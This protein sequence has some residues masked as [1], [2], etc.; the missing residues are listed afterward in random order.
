M[1]QPL[2]ALRDVNLQLGGTHVLQ[3]IDLQLHKARITT[4]IG[5]NGAGKTSLAKVVLGLHTP[6]S[7]TLTRK[8]GLKIGYMPQRL[9]IDDSLPLT[10]DRFLWLADPAHKNERRA[11]LERVDVAELQFKPVQQLSGGE[12][13]RVLLARALLRKADLLV[14]DEPAQGVDV[15]GQNALYGLLAEVRDEM[16]C[17]ILL[18]SHDLHLVMAATDEVICLQ[19][20]V[21]CSGTPEAVSKDPAF[22]DMFGGAQI[23]AANL[24]LYTHDHDHAHDLHGNVDADGNHIHGDHCGHHHD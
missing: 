19:H 5:P 24:A 15:I 6:S 7:G 12:W 18:I 23:P 21:C 20:H 13:Q 2:V 1:S 10:V 17:G 14:L 9:R 3:H 22:H 11:A 16:H 4:L 8:P